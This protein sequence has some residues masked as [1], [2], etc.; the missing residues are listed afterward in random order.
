MTFPGAA[1]GA[2]H[3][4]ANLLG[5]FL[6]VAEMTPPEGVLIDAA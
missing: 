3:E 1:R 2:A 4:A 6:M 5:P